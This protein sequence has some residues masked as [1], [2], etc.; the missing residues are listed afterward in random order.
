M[1]R[2]NDPRK[3]I[4]IFFSFKPFFSLLPSGLASKL[5]LRKVYKYVDYPV[6][7]VIFVI[8]S[9]NSSSRIVYGKFWALFAV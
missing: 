9:S 8:S 6:R 5:K 3:C 2:T 7:K 1:C 4:E